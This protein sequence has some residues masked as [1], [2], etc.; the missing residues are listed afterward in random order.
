MKDASLDGGTSPLLPVARQDKSEDTVHEESVQC[1]ALLACFSYTVCSVGMVIANKA[2]AVVLHEEVREKLPRFSIILFQCIL[3]VVLVEAAKR[4]KIVEY[5]DF[6]VKV[7]KQWFPLNLLFIGMLCTGF[8]SLV[9]VSVP[10]VTVFKNLA[11]LVVSELS[12]LNYI[13]RSYNSP[14]NTFIL[15]IA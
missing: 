10:I 5:P 2:V 9:Y 14:Q 15:M 8:L 1:N 7:A 3:A 4:L 13:S 11:S 6:N 12:F